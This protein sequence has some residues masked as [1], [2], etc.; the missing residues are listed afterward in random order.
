M[1][2]VPEPKKDFLWFPEANASPPAV[3]SR[4]FESFPNLA[5]KDIV[6]PP[7]EFG[8]VPVIRAC[9]ARLKSAREKESTNR[10]LSTLLAVVVKVQKDLE[11]LVG[12]GVSTDAVG[13]V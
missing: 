6:M 11:A 4:P 8:W 5:P 3:V 9:I 10:N 7:Y 13:G 1:V 12:E 2:T